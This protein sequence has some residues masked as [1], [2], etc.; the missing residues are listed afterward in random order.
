MSYRSCGG[1]GRSRA[2]VIIG[3]H[4]GLIL[5]V[6]SVTF[7]VFPANK[8]PCKNKFGDYG[9][10]ILPAGETRARRISAAICNEQATKPAVQK[11]S[12]L[13]ST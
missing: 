2:V 12:E 8:G 13:V 5:G 4:N 10:G 9:A 6:P 11:T 3:Y 7:F 1:L